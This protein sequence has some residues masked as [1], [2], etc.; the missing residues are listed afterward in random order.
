MTPIRLV[1]GLAVALGVLAGAAVADTAQ[2]TAPAAPET[3][4]TCGMQAAQKLIGQPFS[5]IDPM[6]VPGPI[7][8]I[9]PG[10]MVTQDYNP[11]RLDV[12]VNGSGVIIRLHCG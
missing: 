4:D 8:I 10:D 2:T 12:E 9:H 11:A 5:G 3:A 1:A 7:R 6:T